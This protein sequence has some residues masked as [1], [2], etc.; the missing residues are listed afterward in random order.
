[1]NLRAPKTG[2]SSD[3]AAHVV[4]ISSW[5]RCAYSGL[6]RAQPGDHYPSVSSAMSHGEADDYGLRQARPLPSCCAGLLGE[7]RNTPSQPGLAQR[8]GLHGVS[9]RWPNAVPPRGSAQ[10]ADRTT[11]RACAHGEARSVAIRR[12]RRPLPRRHPLVTSHLLGSLPR[13]ARPALGATRPSA[14]IASGRVRNRGPW[15]MPHAARSVSRA[16]IASIGGSGS[17]IRGERILGSCSEAVGDRP[18]A[19]PLSRRR[20]GRRGRA[21]PQRGAVGQRASV[22]SRAVGN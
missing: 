5:Y 13:G 3:R 12:T 18:A 7:T 8:S 20:D 6:R 9:W 15:S 2:D 16:G 4:D 21:A 17:R 19:G 14:G 10:K 22:G 11:R 1:M